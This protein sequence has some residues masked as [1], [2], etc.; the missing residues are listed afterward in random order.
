MGH[1]DGS[2]VPLS[3][4]SGT[5]EPSPCPTQRLLAVVVVDDDGEVIVRNEGLQLGS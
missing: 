5:K 4:K 2:F 1:G 3:S